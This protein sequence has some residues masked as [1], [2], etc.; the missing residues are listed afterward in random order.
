MGRGFHTKV[1]SE[2]GRPV[3]TSQI[4][5]PGEFGRLNSGQII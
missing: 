4:L 3:S 2:V 5:I 1:T